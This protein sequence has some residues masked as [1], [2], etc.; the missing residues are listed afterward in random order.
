MRYQM[1]TLL[2]FLGAL[3]AFG[4]ALIIDAGVRLVRGQRR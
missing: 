4:V 1:I 3:F 2:I